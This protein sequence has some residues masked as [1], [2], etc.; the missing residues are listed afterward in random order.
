[1]FQVVSHYDQEIT[2]LHGSLYLARLTGN[3]AKLNFISTSDPML[4]INLSQVR[5]GGGEEKLEAGQWPGRKGGPW[6][7]QAQLAMQGVNRVGELL[8]RRLGGPHLVLLP[9]GLNI[10]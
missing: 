3:T 2:S 7:H 1:M 5:R 6:D 8:S 10:T 9:V 4:Q